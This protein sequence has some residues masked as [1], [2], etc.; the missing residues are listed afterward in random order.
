M[1][2]MGSLGA[3]MRASQR[4][5]MGATFDDA[6]AQAASADA[7][8]IGESAPAASAADTTGDTAGQQVLGTAGGQEP[9]ARVDAGASTTGDVLNAALQAFLDAAE[10][11]NQNVGTYDATVTGSQVN[12]RADP[13]TSGSVLEQ[14]NRGDVV[15]VT[16]AGISGPGAPANGWFPV[17][18]PDGQQGYISGAYIAPV[19]TSSPITPASPA[20]PAPAA[21]AGPAPLA[22]PASPLVGPS[23]VPGFGQK[24]VGWVKAHKVLAG[25]GALGI[26][27]AVGVTWWGV[28]EA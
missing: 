17:N 24:V 1:R 16:G 25:V 28:S 9:D 26:V 2:A 11:S 15:T 20:S 12:L 18:A 3:R 23:E 4:W 5:G 27:V 19:G 13:S 6:S 7:A 21:P 22:S 14:L 8:T 10:Q